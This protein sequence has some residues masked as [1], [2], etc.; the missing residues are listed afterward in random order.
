MC[1]IIDANV[2]HEVFGDNKNEAGQGFYEWVSEGKVRL[3]VG[4][5]LYEELR[6]ASRIFRELIPE[7]QRSGK[8]T[9]MD[10]DE[11]NNRTEEL[12]TDGSCESDDAHVVALA[13]ISG[14]RL[15][16]SNDSDLNKISKTPI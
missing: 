6:V 8:M 12:L 1:A 16:Y 5:K 2:V 9:E 10:N 3:V 14:A 11:V 15:L 13:Q 7:L 4:G